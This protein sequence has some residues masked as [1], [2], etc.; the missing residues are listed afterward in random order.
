MNAETSRP[1]ITN[2]RRVIRMS[3]Q[4]SIDRL[5]A[6]QASWRFRLFAPWWERDAVQHA[7]TV[8]LREVER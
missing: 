2:E 6:K 3:H 7:L 5:R 4:W 1:L 8:L